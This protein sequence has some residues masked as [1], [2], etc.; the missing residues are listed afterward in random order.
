MAPWNTQLEYVL[1]PEGFL[2]V[3]AEKSDAKVSTETMKGKKYTVITFMGDNK[4]P[5]K[6]YINDMGYV[7]EWKPPSRGWIRSAMP[8]AFAEYDGY[9]DFNGVKFPTHI[10]QRQ[11]PVKAPPKPF[12]LTVSDVK[13]NVP[14]DLAAPGSRRPVEAEGL[15]RKAD[16]PRRSRRRSS[17]GGRWRKRRT[18]VLRWWQR[19]S[20]RRRAGGR[21]AAVSLRRILATALG[22]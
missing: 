8:S 5:V 21:G 3:A 4:Q 10:V 15:R 14:V 11:G 22:W 9:K 18:A 20:R 6:G 1:L 19:R 2:K 16:S 17:S 13:V 12:E 7:T